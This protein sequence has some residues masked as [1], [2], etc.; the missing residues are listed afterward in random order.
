MEKYLQIE[1]KQLIWWE[2]QQGIVFL[3]T[4]YIKDLF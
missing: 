1:M 2:E 4:F 3:T